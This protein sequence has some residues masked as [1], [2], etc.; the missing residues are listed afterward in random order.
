MDERG[1]YFEFA[2]ITWWQNIRLKA[3]RPEISFLAAGGLAF[4]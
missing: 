4:I 1:K 2:G 3:E